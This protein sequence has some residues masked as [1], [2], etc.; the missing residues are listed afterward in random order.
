MQSID[1]INFK[2][3]VLC[4]QSMKSCEKVRCANGHYAFTNTIILLNMLEDKLLGFVSFLSA[5]WLVSYTI[6]LKNTSGFFLHCSGGTLF[7]CSVN[8][9]GHSSWVLLQQI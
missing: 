6:V 2:H 5:Y 8:H 4:V 9:L 1:G 7:Y 3:L